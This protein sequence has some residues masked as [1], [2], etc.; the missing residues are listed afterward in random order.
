MKSE[1]ENLQLAAAHQ[2]TG[3]ARLHALPEDSEYTKE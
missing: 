2:E 3:E 1:T